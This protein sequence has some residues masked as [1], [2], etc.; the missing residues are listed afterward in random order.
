MEIWLQG[1]IEEKRRWSESLEAERTVF[2]RA[3]LK[4]K[5]HQLLKSIE[6]NKNH[7]R[8]LQERLTPDIWAVC[9]GGQERTR[10]INSWWLP[11]LK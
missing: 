4:G 9:D 3:P 5:S 11:L 10:S 1:E 6:D 2:K 7:V 8:V